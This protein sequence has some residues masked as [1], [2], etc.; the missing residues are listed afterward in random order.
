MKVGGTV[1]SRA[2][3]AVASNTA[4]HFHSITELALSAAHDSHDADKRFDI[5]LVRD[6]VDPLDC[7]WLKALF[8]T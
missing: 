8:F 3:L 5:F 4:K 2:S 1:K 6:C 7:R